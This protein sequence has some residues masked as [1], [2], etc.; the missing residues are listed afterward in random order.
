MGWRVQDAKPD[1]SRGSALAVAAVIVAVLLLGMWL[2]FIFFFGPLFRGL[3]CCNNVESLAIGLQMYA[4][5]FGAFPPA[6]SWCDKTLEYTGNRAV[7]GCPERSDLPCGYAYNSALSELRPD[8]IT[9]P[10]HT[11]IVFESDRGWNAAGGRELLV[12]RPRHGGA[13]YFGF[14]GGEMNSPRPIA[15]VVRREDL[16][17][18]RAGLWWNAS[19]GKQP[20][21]RT[22]VGPRESPP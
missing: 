3:E 7:F 4:A 18:G 19:E 9:D 17:R 12:A 5:D 10:D 16:D 21:A 20:S 14:A 6:D 13:D 2:G 22:L 11:I 15:K 8:E 1:R